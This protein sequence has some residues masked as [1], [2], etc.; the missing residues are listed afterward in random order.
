MMWTYKQSTGEL[1]LDGRP[2]IGED[3]PARGHSGDRNH[4]NRPESESLP[5]LGPIPRG[6]YTIGLSF[7]VGSDPVT[8]DLSPALGQ[9]MYGR[10]GF[11]IHGPADDSHG[12]IVFDRAIRDAID[13]S[14][15]RDL[16]VIR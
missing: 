11:Q 14:P 8:M 6:R 9:K 16:E 2:Y 7:R 1:Y 12:C 4:R 3:G 15:D 10:G 13:A 5:N